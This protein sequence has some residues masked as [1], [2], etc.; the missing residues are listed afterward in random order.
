MRTHPLAVIVYVLLHP[1]IVIVGV[2]V[3]DMNGVCMRL[4]FVRLVLGLVFFLAFYST[5]RSLSRLRLLLEVECR[6][7]SFL[8]VYNVGLVVQL[9]QAGRDMTTSFVSRAILVTRAASCRATF[10]VSSAITVS[11]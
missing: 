7:R 4:A 11:R 10:T 6:S 8:I 9:E 1:H 3:R 5:S 2:I